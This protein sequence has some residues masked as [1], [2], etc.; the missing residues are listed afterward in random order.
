MRYI[1]DAR[2]INGEFVS[3]SSITPSDICLH[4]DKKTQAEKYMMLWKMGFKG[5]IDDESI[6]SKL[7]KCKDIGPGIPQLKVYFIQEMKLEE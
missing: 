4:P 1:F 2:L 3:F 5:P 6:E 7:E